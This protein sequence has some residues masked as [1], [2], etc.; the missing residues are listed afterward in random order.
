MVLPILSVFRFALYERKNEIQKKK[1]YRSVEGS[2][3]DCISPVIKTSQ[4]CGA[5]APHHWDV[6]LNA[7]LLVIRHACRADSDT[8]NHSRAHEESE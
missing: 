6:Y 4:W 3:A 2:I 8:F 1:K 7:S 5:A